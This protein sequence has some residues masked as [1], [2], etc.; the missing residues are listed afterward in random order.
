MVAVVANHDLGSKTLLNGFITAAGAT[1][2]QDLNDALDNIFNHPNVGPYIS[3]HLIRELVTSNPSPAYIQR[4]ATIFDDNGSGVRGD[5]KAVVKAILLDPE[6]RQISPSDPKYGHLKDPV[7]LMLDFLR[8]MNPTAANGQGASDG[9]L[10]PQALSL[11][12][13][14]LEPPT[15]FSY[16]PADYVLPGTSVG[17]PEFG[18]FQTVT[19]LKRP[20]FF[21]TMIFSNIPTSANAPNG[22]AIDLSWW[23]ILASNPAALV[24][25]LNRRFLHDS[26]SPQMQTSILGAINAISPSNPLLRAQT[27]L[28]LVATSSQYQVER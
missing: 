10:A 6:A 15:V 7:L 19:A 1:P 2:L 20:N 26:M 17:A 4:I 18:I 11:G 25:E 12:Q 5:L 23:T 28:Y 13:N 21:N 3:R 14:I 9:Y 27:G 22:T 16:Y 8:A 24:Q